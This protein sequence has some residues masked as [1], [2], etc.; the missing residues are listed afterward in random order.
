MLEELYEM[1]RIAY[2][3]A[4]SLMNCLEKLISVLSYDIYRLSVIA[5]LAFLPFLLA[6]LLMSAYISDRNI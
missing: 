4:G 1:I 6:S 2:I 3:I 5:A